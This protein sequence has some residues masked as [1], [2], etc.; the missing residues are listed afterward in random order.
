MNCND[1]KYIQDAPLIPFEDNYIAARFLYR[2]K[3]FSVAVEL[4]GEETWVHSNNSG[5]MLGLVRKGMPILLSKA[6]NPARKL[7]Y[8]QECVWLAPSVPENCP[9]NPHE[10]LQD[11]QCFWVG[12]NT[13]VPNKLLQAAFTNNALP[14]AKGYTK[15]MREAKRGQSR[16]DACLTAENLPT[17]WVECK[18]VT[19]VEDC[20]A[21]FPDA[22]TERGQKHLL[23]LMDIVKAGERAAMFYLIQRPD[24]KCFGPADMIDPDYAKLFW[25]AVKMGVEV[26]PFMASIT[27]KG[28]FLGQCLPLVQQGS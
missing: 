11:N 5:S 13:S 6:N 4:S 28:I 16:L 25:E 2:H 1:L 21:L 22:R 14:F 27:A 12:V 23:E 3:R 7:A 26:Y 9:T 19:M 24:A 8:T 10:Y 20:V 17:L 15:F 18:N